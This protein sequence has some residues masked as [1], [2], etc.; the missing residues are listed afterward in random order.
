MLDEVAKHL[1]DLKF[2]ARGKRGVLFAATLLGSGAQVVVKFAGDPSVSTSS[3]AAGCWVETEARWIRIMNRIGVGARLEAFGTGWLICE[4]LAGF[5]I[6]EFLSS[7]ATRSS[8]R[9]VLREILCQCFAIDMMGINKEEMTHPTRHII[10][11]ALPCPSSSA[12]WRWKCTFIDFEKCSYSAKP[13]NITQICQFITSPRMTA[14]FLKHG[15]LWDLQQVRQH[16]KCYKTN[17]S[18]K[19]FDGL[20]R[21]FNL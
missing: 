18:S 16:T 5:N 6:V 1:N 20:L 15:V 17:V 13:K 9:W 4:R 14:L 21:V 12:R 3:T 2:F 11:H 19:A 10:V 7:H 8:A